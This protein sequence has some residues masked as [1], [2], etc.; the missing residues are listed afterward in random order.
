[1]IGNNLRVAR[2]NAGYTQSQVMDITWDKKNR[3]RI[4]DIENGKVTIDIY[5]FL[6]LVD[7][8]G[9]SVDFILGRSCEPIN[10]VK[11]AFVNNVK[12][13]THKF[14]QPIIDS[15][16][17]VVVN[18][19]KRHDID[20]YLDLMVAAKNLSIYAVTNAAKINSQKPELYAMLSK[21]GD[22]CRSLE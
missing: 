12:L 11:A 22:I 2:Q 1:V 15:M 21:L 5:T 6:I 18:N 14:I 9:Q 19:I 13:N 10:D 3:N 8:Y 20:K 17:E 7:L 4:S 16:T